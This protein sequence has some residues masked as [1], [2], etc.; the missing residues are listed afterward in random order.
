MTIGFELFADLCLADWLVHSGIA[1][2][3]VF[4]AKAFPW[5]VSDTTLKDFNWTL[6]ALEEHARST[7]IGQLSFRIQTWRRY[8]QEGIWTV[9][10]DRFWTLPYSFWQL[11]TAGKPI[12]DELCRSD[13]LILKGDLNYRKAVYDAVSVS[14]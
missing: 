9:T 1:S 12:Y 5:F 14:Y 11:P 4:H 2:R 13:F 6:N 10:A 7:N 3:V 8:L